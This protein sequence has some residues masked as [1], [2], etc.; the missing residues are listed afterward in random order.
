MKSL[1]PVSGQ[2]FLLTLVLLYNLSGQV[3]ASSCTGSYSHTDTG[4]GN[5]YTLNAGQSLKIASGTYT[6]TVEFGTG[7]SICVETGASFA[8]GNLNNAAGTLTNYGTASLQTFSYNSGTVIDN[9]GTLSFVGG[10]NTNGATTFRNRTNATMN[11]ANSFQLGNNSTFINDGLVVAQQDFNTQNGTTLTNNHR[12]EL[13][14]NFNPDGKFDNYGRVYAKKFMNINANSDVSNY[15]TLVSYDGFNNNSPLMDNEGTIL[16]TTAAGTPGG[17]WQNNQAFHNGSNAKIAGGNF[18]NNSTFT[19]G[20]RMIFSGDTRNQ[21][22]FDGNSIADNITFYDETQTGAQIFDVIGVTPTNTVRTVFARPTEMDAPNN[23]SVT[24]KAFTL[25][26]TT[27]AISGTI[28]TDNNGDDSYDAGA[29]PGIGAVTVNLLNQASGAV[30]ATVS[31]AADGQYSFSNVDPA[32][33]YRISVDTADTDLGGKTIGTP[34]PLAGVTVTAG[35]T[36]T[37]Q[38]FGF[39][40]LFPTQICGQTVDNPLELDFSGTA[41][42]VSGTA[43]QPGSVYRFSSVTSGVDALVTLNALQADLLERW[44]E[45]DLGGKL[46]GAQADKYFDMT[47]NL[48]NTGTSTAISPVDLVLMSF[49]LDG[50]A[51]E[52]YSDGIEYFST[53]ATFSGAGSKLQAVDM[54]GSIRYT[55]PPSAR[56]IDDPSAVDPA[57]AAGAVY[58]NITSFRTKGLV[59]DDNG[60][61]AR[62]IFIYAD[63]ASFKHFGALECDTQVSTSDVSG[64]IFEDVNYGGDAGRPFGTAGTV[65]V[66]GA[67]VELYNASGQY[68]RYTTTGAGGTYT[69]GELPDGNYFIRVVNDSVSSSRSGSDGSE[70]PVQTY[71]SNGASATSNEIGGHK[72]AVAD[73]AANTTNLK[74]NTSNFTFPGNTQA[75]SVQ[76]V[77]VTGSDISGVSFGFNFDTIVNTNNDGQGSLRQFLLNANLLAGDASLTQSGRVAGKE[78]AILMLPAND[79]NYSGGAWKITLAS[80]LQDISK[81]LVLD[82]SKQAT[83]NSATGVPVIELNGKGGAGNG[84]TLVAGSS[85]SQIRSLAITQFSGDGVNVQGGTAGN[86][87]LGN[88]I[89]DNGRLGINLVDGSDNAFGVT[90]NDVGDNDSGANDLLNYPDVQAA[91]FGANGS[92]IITHDFILDVPAGDYRIEFF[93]STSKDPSGNGEGQTFLGGKDFS[94]PGTGALNFKGS[95]NANQAVSSAEF[96]TVTVTRKTGAATYGSTSEFSGA[97]TN[98]TALV[99]TDLLSNPGAA[100]PNLMI[101]ENAAVITY[102]KARDSSGNPIT[103]A[104]SGGVDGNM[105]TIAPPV[106]GTVDC[107]QLQFVKNVIIKNAPAQARAVIPGGLPAPG[108]FEVPLDQGKDNVYDLEITATDSN[109]QKYVRTLSMGVMDVNE[110]PLITSSAA[111]SVEEDG[112]KLALDINSQ[113][114]DA[115]DV[116]GDGLAYSLSGGAD[117][118]QFTLDN[119]TGVLNFKAVPDHDAPTDQ[120]QDN[121]YEVSVTVTDHGGLETEKT[122]NITVLNRAVDDGVKLQARA[123]LQGAYDSSSGMMAAKLNTLG[124]LPDAQPYSTAPFNHAGAET[125]GIPV[126]E[127]TGNDAMVD[128]IL[129]ELRSSSATVVSSRAVAIQGDGDLVDPQT[130]SSILSFGGIPAGNYYVSLRHRNH[131]GVITASPVSL[132]SAATLV[133]FSLT[134][135]ATKGTDARYITGSTA[136]LWVGDINASNTLTTSGPGNDTTVMLSAILTSNENPAAHTN[137]ALHGYL[138]TDLNMDGKTLFS[139]PGND[140]N[141]LIGNV[142]LHPLNGNNAANYIVKGG[143]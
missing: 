84:L 47:V 108:N 12:L 139:G 95:F 70:L 116:E 100:L 56:G 72:P 120:N 125:L 117:Q 80:T 34:N 53:A 123:L 30:V 89:H 83:F 7:A 44:L 11:M 26:A 77:S 35:D 14:G 143:L 97:A 113:D 2:Y 73:A 110:A 131:L 115:G 24:Y 68:L 118:H 40:P 10:L 81:P 94:H 48:V 27:G 67:R 39:D 132:G 9:Y 140:I 18:I 17:S 134:T 105:F 21:G 4:T 59:V 98:N 86:A 91:S 107:S 43:K 111:V 31:T 61:S 57:Y 88:S 106:N 85:G 128:W 19:G 49:D 102:L 1:Q 60:S 5:N 42:L 29:E 90:A 32:L 33:T 136:L 93:K 112:S 82:G 78:N 23:C 76:P 45:G 62:S 36:T 135:T 55:L 142:I 16:I 75:Q 137:Y 8:P 114:Q 96:I 119:Q 66:S 129:V 122:F 46:R 37:G 28:Y 87:I 38:D 52:P 41:T 121:V 141:N 65:G 103:Y 22:P 104:I 99:C 127:A 71:R 133:D 101:D 13:E 51:G 3:W 138:P 109:G 6:G 63:A 74:L 54:G 79:P 64:V 15:C 130:G 50:S 20:G 69:F 126:R 92:K 25:K 124:L 58:S